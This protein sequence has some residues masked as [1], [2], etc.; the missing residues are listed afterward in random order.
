MST[1]QQDTQAKAEQYAGHNVI[2]EIMWFLKMACVRQKLRS[3]WAQPN[4]L[5]MPQSG[6]ILEGSIRL[7]RPT[8]LLGSLQG[9]TQTSPSTGCLGCGLLLRLQWPGQDWGT[10]AEAQ[11]SLSLRA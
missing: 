11:L 8:E 3:W 6:L 5:H 9:A 10:L 2:L 7:L 1:Q 4:Q